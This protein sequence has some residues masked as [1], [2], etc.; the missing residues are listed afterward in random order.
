MSYSF[1]ISGHSPDPHNDEI[2]A[3]AEE[4][5]QRLPQFWNWTGGM[6]PTSTSGVTVTG[7]PYTTNTTSSANYY[8]ASAVAA[9]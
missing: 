3:M 9:K 2:K 6:V 1:T 8:S 5:V 7:V 4:C